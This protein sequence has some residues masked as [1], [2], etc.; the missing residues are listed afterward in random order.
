MSIKRGGL[1]VK[2]GNGMMMGVFIL[3]CGKMEKGLEGRNM[4]WMQ[5]DRIRF[6]KV[7]ITIRVKRS[8]K[9]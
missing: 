2:V 1:R 6:I 3:V 8:K 4:F 7:N 9:I 5:M